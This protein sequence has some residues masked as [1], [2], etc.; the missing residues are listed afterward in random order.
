MKSNKI[1]TYR[2]KDWCMPLDELIARQS[3]NHYVNHALF[4]RLRQLLI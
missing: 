1:V 2:S 3:E 4:F